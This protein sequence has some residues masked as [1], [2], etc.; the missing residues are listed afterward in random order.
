MYKQGVG[1]SLDVW[2]LFL[3]LG[4]DVH[5]WETLCCVVEAFISLRQVPMGVQCCDTLGASYCSPQE[6]TDR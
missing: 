5:A 2:A 4:Y 1:D 6:P 3:P